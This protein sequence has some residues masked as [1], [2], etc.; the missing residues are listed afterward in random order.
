MRHALLLPSLLLLAT[1]AL[2]AE[3]ACE[4]PFAADSSV[5]RL[6]EA[7]GAENVVTGDSPGPEGTTVLATTVY[8]DDP[9]RTM[10]FGWW[11]EENLSELSYVELAPGD[12]AFGV[13]RGMGVDAVEAL[14]GE[15]F[16]MT[17]LW[18]DYGGY[19]GFQ[20]GAL[21]ELA[22]DCS[23]SL[24][25]DTALN[26]PDGLDVGSISGDQQIA[27]DEPLLEQL[28]VEVTQVTLGYAYP[29][30]DQVEGIEMPEAQAGG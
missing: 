9:D 8:P 23:L 16:T 7:F 28:S 20:S 17:G 5:A 15:A 14:N 13:S 11:D 1:P 3:I 12:S 2:A 21:A 4:G 29:G 24:R 6:Q 10:V 27:S 19:A 22:G 18:W 30:L 25:F 26:V